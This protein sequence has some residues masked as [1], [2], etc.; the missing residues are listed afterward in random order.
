MKNRL[1]WFGSFLLVWVAFVVVRL[2][3]LQIENHETYSRKAG[4]QQQRVVEID[5]PRG[6]I[7]DARGRELAVSVEVD[8]AFAVPRE[9]EDPAGVAQA[10][11]KILGK[12]SRKI[13]TL[14]EGDG[15]FAW[16]ER[17]LD[18]PVA[19]AIRELDLPGI[20]FLQ[21]YKRYYPMGDLAAS[22]LGFVG[23]DNQGLGGLEVQYNSRIAGKPGRRTVLKDARRSTSSPPTLPAADAEP[24]EDLY[25]TLDASIQHLAE[26]ELKRAVEDNRAR[27]GSI[28]LLDPMRGAVLA[29]ATY[30]TFDPNHFRRFSKAQRRNRAIMDAFEPGSTFKMV[31]FA[32]A[33]DRNLI[34]PN[35]QVDCEMG[36]IRFGRTRIRDYKPFGVL[37]YREVLSKSSNVG[38]IKAS[39][40]IPLEEFYSTIR[41]FGFGSVS[42]IDLPGES[43]GLLRA[44]EQWTV[45]EP[46][47]IS[48]GQGIGTTALQV[49]NGFATLANGGTLL[50]PYVV[51]AVGRGGEK[52]PFHGEP[53]VLGRPIDASTALQLE[54]MLEGV[55]TT[56]ATGAAAQIAGFIVAGKTGTAQTAEEGGYSP[57]RRVPSFAGFAPARRPRVAGLVVIDSPRAGLTGGGS[58]AAPVFSRVVGRVLSY[59]GVAPDE[60][61]SEDIWPEQQVRIRDGGSFSGELQDA[62]VKTGSFLRSKKWTVC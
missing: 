30:P 52:V 11:A 45:L 1:T 2:Y 19:A 13:A 26:V 15:E 62:E 6:T 48:F 51:E 47:Y 57:D 3:I 16:L 35:D 59:L 18:P 36:G 56:G 38:T 43:P 50:E 39:M 17:K 60:G 33:L 37:T 5:P 10:L 28:V 42:G 7:Y 40:K 25:L 27:G 32:A 46:R 61:P 58:V 34:D 8:S 21:E 31:T 14:L 54:R 53:R 44:P 55:V 12:D 20:H 41:G 49:A 4:Q 9:I 22:V 29:M 24:G 23:V